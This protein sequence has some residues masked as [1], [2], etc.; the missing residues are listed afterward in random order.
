MNTLPFELLHNVLKPIHYFRRNKY[1][2]CNKLLS[3]ILLK[4][5]NNRQLIFTHSSGIQSDLYRPLT[6][7][8]IS[9]W[10]TNY[11]QKNE[12]IISLD[13][14]SRFMKCRGKIPLVTQLIINIVDLA[15]LNHH[16]DYL[17]NIIKLKITTR[18]RFIEFPDIINLPL[19]KLRHLIVH[20]EGYDE[21][22]GTG[23]DR[24]GE[25]VNVYLEKYKNQS[26][27]E[28]LKK[29][30]KLVL[31]IQSGKSRYILTNDKLESDNLLKKLY[32]QSVMKF[33]YRLS[34]LTIE[35]AICIDI[36]CND[37][38]LEL[39]NLRYLC[40][41]TRTTTCN[42]SINGCQLPLNLKYLIHNGTVNEPDLINSTGKSRRDEPDLI[43]S[44][45]KSLR[46]EPIKKSLKCKLVYPSSVHSNLKRTNYVTHLELINHGNHGNIFLPSSLKYIKFLAYDNSMVIN[47]LPD[48]LKVII[49]KHRFSGNIDKLP[50]KLKVLF[51]S[52]FTDKICE[53]P[54]SL[55]A[56]K[57]PGK[58]KDQ[59]PKSC[60]RVILT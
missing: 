45:G 41:N 34:Q 24:D 44:T 4:F 7:E 26:V 15:F 23:S 38:L 2:S 8:Y 33:L 37:M 18:N 9:L 47:A 48:T 12:F 35:S 58:Y 40:L 5:T 14:A 39:T 30:D 13:T 3:I 46:D 60:K 6:N 49:C 17:E 36:V 54:S 31:N 16:P 32:C 50:S 53:L 52:S 21:Y 57:I 27:F 25:D 20:E 1:L 55:Y 43:N 22:S 10:I 28:R 42:S 59:I 19:N 11:H 29:E 56:V 51:L